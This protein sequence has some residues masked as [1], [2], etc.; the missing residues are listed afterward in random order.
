VLD[1]RVR[2]HEI[3]RPFRKRQRH[4]VRQSEVQIA[5]ATL[6]REPDRRVTESIEG[7]DAHDVARLF[8]Q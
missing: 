5:H 6:A 8:G 4:A 7:I 1:D 2:Q 3:E